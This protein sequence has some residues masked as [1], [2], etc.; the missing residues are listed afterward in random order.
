MRFEVQKE[1]NDGGWRTEPSSYPVWDGHSTLDRARG[2]EI[3]VER[4]TS[5]PDGTI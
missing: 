5:D 2:R 3:L 1:D 4:G